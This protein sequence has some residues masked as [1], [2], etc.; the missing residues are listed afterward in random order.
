MA[1]KF[2]NTW[3]G[4]YWLRSLTH[5]DYANRIPRGASYARAGHVVNI[6][7]NKNVV[8]AKVRGSV[9]TPYKEKI[10][11]PTF[12]KEETNKLVSGIME[13]PAL[14]P[15]LLNRELSPEIQDI[16]KQCG[17]KVFPTAWSDFEMECNCPDWAVPCKH[18]AAVIYMLSREIDNNP[19]LVFEMHGVDFFSE[20][21]KREIVI[22]IQKKMAV[23]SL[24][25]CFIPLKKENDKIDDNNDFFKLDF[26][27]ID[28]MGEALTSLLADAPPF[29]PDRDFKTVF[30]D[31]V[32][33]L[34]NK[35]KRL[36]NKKISFEE[37]TGTENSVGL[38][39][40]HSD[41]AIVVNDNFEWT[42]NH[43]RT[44][45]PQKK[46]QKT[47]SEEELM[48]NLLTL[49]PD[50]VEDYQASVAILYQVLLFSVHLLS[51]GAVLPNIYETG[52]KKYV[53]RWMAA[54]L[55]S[56]V[57]KLVHDCDKILFNGLITVLTDKKI[58]E[59]QPVDGAAWIVSLFLNA[60]IKNMSHP[61]LHYEEIDSMFFYGKCHQFNR[62][63]E[64]ECAG[65]I[66]AWL[67]RYFVGTHKYRPIIMVDEDKMDG[68]L[69]D[70]DIEKQGDITKMQ[71]RQILNEEV[72][73]DQRFPILSELSLLSALIIGLDK[74]INNKA[75]RPIHLYNKDFIPFLIQ[76]IPALRMLNV[77]VV[78]PKSLQNMIKPKCSLAIETKNNSKNEKSFIHFED[79]LKFDWQVALGKD[80][81]SIDEFMR[82][83]N[84]A[85][86]LLK[87]K[88]K[89]FYINEKELELLLKAINGTA[90]PSKMQ[91]LQAALTGEYNSAPVILSDEVKELLRLLTSDD[92]ITVPE[93]LNATLRPYQQRGFSWM[94]RNMRIGFGSIIADDMGLGKTLQVITLLLKA[95]HENR[96]SSKK[97]LI[98][99]PTGLI[100]NWISEIS[101]FAPSLTVFVYHGQNRDI[102]QFDVDIMLTSYGI[103]RSDMD[104]IKKIKWQI[105]II[106]EAQNI[107]NLNTN[108]SKAVR[109]ISADI[110]IAMSGT[111]VENR[112]SEFWTIMDY[113]NHGYMDTSKKFKENYA[114][115]IQICGDMKCVER[116]R[117]VTAPFMM[118]R[119]KTDIS[120]ISDLPD[121]VEQNEFALLTPQQ[122][123]L[124]EETRKKALEVIMGLET[125]DSKSL[126]KREGM[127]LQMIL[128]L[129]EICNHPAQF[130][131]DGNFNPKLSGKTEMLLDLV[132]SIV[133]SDEKVII[134]TQF[135]EMGEILKKVILERTSAEPMFL[136][137]RCSMKQRQEMVDRFQNNRADKV[138]L[139]SLKAAGTGLNLTA[140]SHV[141]HYDLWWNPAV[142][143]QAT[144]RAYRIGQHKNV[145]VHR[146]ITKNTFEEKINRMIQDKR[147]LAELT[148]TSG[149]NWIGKLSNKE[150]KEIF[151]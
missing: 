83:L 136:H 71:L 129:K 145:M 28:D 66:K 8:T 35:A 142:E 123:A 144:D 86:G 120:I 25:D 12:S 55:N 9:S 81:I 7:I 117:K 60:L 130:L 41:I 112:L 49:N 143:A 78:L 15:K 16:A 121:K 3:W 47:L 77:K 151:G 17:L 148:V 61:T 141:I 67:D 149:E 98:V 53:I 84:N 95:K 91:M 4:N 37:I 64:K 23:K 52:E 51:H 43:Q 85:S 100:L 113:V 76:S 127:I 111:P 33:Y 54:E 75:A 139:L 6:N 22:D 31:E 18:L 1:T 125:D 118:R 10:T 21:E 19:F 132:Q 82:L 44:D 101:R 138:F 38:I 140:A 124:Y 128:A 72:Y 36:I 29:Y 99:V 106:D 24:S 108:Q 105:M 93:D 20:L 97:F 79:L 62:I 102:C 65:G 63:G 32:T 11:I 88:E 137:G 34:S 115:P 109:S 5:I 39:S 114:T 146:F 14:I 135:H 80:V 87:F 74:Y 2:G 13:H 69:I 134:F 147:E 104:K 40:Q 150:L 48:S 110:H 73:T 70:I 116:F 46:Y 50:Y 42:I 94:Y 119:L 92:E 107:K 45:N 30:H 68:F 133:E 26:S 96:E 27:K 59:I 131:K 58:K 89:Y 103:L 57:R 122:L 126:F 56:E 90:K